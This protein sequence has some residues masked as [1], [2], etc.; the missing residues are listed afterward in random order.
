MIPQ[1]NSSDRRALRRIKFK[2]RS[3]QDKYGAGFV[4]CIALVGSN[5]HSRG[6]VD[7]TEWE[8]KKGHLRTTTGRTRCSGRL[9]FPRSQAGPRFGML[10]EEMSQR[11]E[12]LRGVL[13]ATV[14]KCLVNVV[15]DHAANPFAAMRVRNEIVGQRRRCDFR[16]VFMLGDRSHLLFIKTAKADAVYQRNHI[17]CPGRAHL[18]AHQRVK[19]LA[20]E[21]RHIDLDQTG[22]C[23]CPSIGTRT[24]GAR[25]H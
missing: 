18:C 1:Q 24:R 2:R 8:G 19:K 11:H 21:D 17:G 15:N 12:K 13:N 16:N 23:T 9:H 25:P 14:V 7:W 4:T 6:S 10:I 20:R 5:S 3:L 22:Q